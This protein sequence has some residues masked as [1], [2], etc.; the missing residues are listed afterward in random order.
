MDDVGGIPAGSESEEEP[1]R[2]AATKGKA[3]SLIAMC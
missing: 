1:K 2:K 3:V